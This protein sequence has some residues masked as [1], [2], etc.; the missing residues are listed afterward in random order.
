MSIFL[1]IKIGSDEGDMVGFDARRS[2]LGEYLRVYGGP[3]VIRQVYERARIA[4][5]EN[6][7]IIPAEGSELSDIVRDFKAGEKFE[8][9]RTKSEDELKTY[10]LGKG[11]HFC[12]GYLSNF[13]EIVRDIP[14]RNGNKPI[15]DKNKD[16]NAY[17]AAKYSWNILMG[18]IKQ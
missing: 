14:Y 12:A 18:K 17:N 9:D 2:A 4:R 15:Y 1:G 7:R 8:N 11:K 13:L 5:D 10:F 6:G 3:K 16:K